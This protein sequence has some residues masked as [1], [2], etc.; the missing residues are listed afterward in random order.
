MYEIRMVK[1]FRK[2]LKALDKSMYDLDEL[3]KV[4]SMLAN[5]QRL[6]PEYHDHDL[7]GK[8][9][10]TRE[11]HIRPDWLLIYRTKKK[12]LILYLLSTGTHSNLLKK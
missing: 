12:E 4:V 6:P 8:F 3:D 1:Q 7:H 2:D 10:G 11:C 5:G 9:E